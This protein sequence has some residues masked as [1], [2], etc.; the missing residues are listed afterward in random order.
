MG[1]G[2]G[3]ALII[4]ARRVGC[5]KL[6][7]RLKGVRVGKATG[8]PIGSDSNSM[9][10][11]CFAFASLSTSVFCRN[12]IVAKGFAACMKVVPVDTAKCLG[13]AKVRWLAWLF[14]ENYYAVNTTTFLEVRAV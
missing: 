14:E 7:N 3:T 9:M 5:L 12:Y 2:K 6:A 1:T 8:R 4:R 11:C 13:L 10:S